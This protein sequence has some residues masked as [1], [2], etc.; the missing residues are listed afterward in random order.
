M[1]LYR[2]TYYSTTLHLKGNGCVV[3]SIGNTLI[4]HLENILP[5]PWVSNLE[6]IAYRLAKVVRGRKAANVGYKSRGKHSAVRFGAIVER[7]GSGQIRHSCD[8]EK[9][10]DFIFCNQKLWKYI[11]VLFAI[12]CPEEARILLSI[13]NELRIFGGMFTAGYWNLEPLDRL[14]R[15]SNDWR[16]CCA[17]VFGDFQKG[18]LDFP[19]INTELQLARCG[20]CFFWSKKV[21]H[22]VKNADISRQSFI[23]TNHTAVLR[24]YN[25]EVDDKCYDC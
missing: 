6:S 1:L 3:D 11:A 17:I 15:D 16:W 7:G 4:L 13:P 8:N 9:L 18:T 24:R 5:S 23:L 20:L 22:T 25:Q 10:K 21:F 2:N 19:I 12:L 14:H